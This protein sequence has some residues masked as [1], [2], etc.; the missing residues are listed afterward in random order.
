MATHH[1]LPDA[2]VSC[3]QVGQ[4]FQHDLLRVAP[5]AHGVQQIHSALHTKPIN[6]ARK[7]YTQGARGSMRTELTVRTV[8]GQCD[9]GSRLEI[10]YSVQKRE[11]SLRNLSRKNDLCSQQN[12]RKATE[13]VK[14]VD[15]KLSH[16][17]CRTLT[18][19][20]VFKALMTVS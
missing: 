2:V 19:R 9:I 7:H 15:K 1:L 5:V 6:M 10:Q 17:T 8:P 20:S 3:L 12:V 13:D 14:I 16:I 11:D 18:S 4:H